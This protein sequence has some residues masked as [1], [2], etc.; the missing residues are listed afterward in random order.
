MSFNKRKVTAAQQTERRIRPSQV[1]LH[2]LPESDVKIN[3]LRQVIKTDPYLALTAVGPSA[4][5]MESYISQCHD[6]MAV[7]IISRIKADGALSLA[8]QR[9][10]ARR[11]AQVIAHHMTADDIE[12]L[13]QRRT[14]WHRYLKTRTVM[15]LR[16]PPGA[17][18]VTALW[19]LGVGLWTLICQS[20]LILRANGVA[21]ELFENFSATQSHYL[22]RNR[23]VKFPGLVSRYTLSQ[24]VQTVINWLTRL[25]SLDGYEDDYAIYLGLL[26]YRAAQL[27]CLSGTPLTGYDAKAWLEQVGHLEQCTPK[28]IAHSMLWFLALHHYLDT[29][30]SISSVNGML[31]AGKPD[32]EM[33]VPVERTYALRWMPSADLRE[34]VRFFFCHYAAK[35]VDQRYMHAMRAMMASFIPLACD[36]FIYRL[37]RQTDHA[38]PKNVVNDDSMTHH[39]P[40]GSEFMRLIMC[41]GTVLQWMHDAVNW[42]YGDTTVRSTASYGRMGFFRELA[43]LF[44]VH[45]WM[46]RLQLL[47]WRF[48]FVLFHRSP[49]FLSNFGKA[50]RHGMP[51]IVQYFNKWCTVGLHQDD[52]DV[53]GDK[54]MRSLDV[55][56]SARQAQDDPVADAAKRALV[57]AA[58]SV[59]APQV[60]LTMA[61]GEEDKDY[62][63]APVPLLPLS[64]ALDEEDADYVDAMAEDA[65]QNDDDGS[66]SYSYSYSYY[67]ND[68]DYESDNSDDDAELDRLLQPHRPPEIVRQEQAAAAAANQE[69]ALDDMAREMGRM[70]YDMA[71]DEGG[72][73]MEENRRTYGDLLPPITA[74]EDYVRIYTCETFL[75]AFTMWLFLLLH[76]NKGMIEKVDLKDFAAL[77]FGW[78]DR[79][80]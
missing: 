50:K 7:A 30:K 40:T 69:T 42:R 44:V 22:T 12:E 15:L 51:F 64:M 68:D 16:A 28:F 38:E 34:R 67:S 24:L 20:N 21:V 73:H 71:E 17:G 62:T 43:T 77:M 52:P 75:D 65:P 25:D 2:K 46:G 4:F 70:A 31:K 33:L 49:A 61:L 56:S 79:H 23:L 66:G 32:I 9:N 13:K 18:G 41:T 3:T 6:V 63:D 35:M 39:S 45:M 19:T 14:Q 26:E 1:P 10:G 36:G 80:Q 8:S 47:R 54:L 76:T 55:M 5:Q 60:P 59:S 37:H 53:D 72:A 11:R 74:N 57:N 78:K 27:I 29:H 58:R 48:R